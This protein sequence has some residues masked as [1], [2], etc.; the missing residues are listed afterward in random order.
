MVF[1]LY[2][3]QRIVYYFNKGF[4]PPTISRLL[5]E[6]GMQASRR[7]IGKFLEKHLETGTIRRRP[8]SGWPTKI[9]AEIKAIVEE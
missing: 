8:G 7:G 9:T 4:K 6:E 5:R 3:R 2:K 1:S